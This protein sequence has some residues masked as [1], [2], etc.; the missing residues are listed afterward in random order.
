MTLTRSA[1]HPRG[2]KI[3][4]NA[5]RSLTHAGVFLDNVLRA[6]LRV[7]PQLGKLIMPATY[8]EIP[9][10]GKG[11]QG[12]RIRDS[13][14]FRQATPSERTCGKLMQRFKEGDI[15][16]QDKKRSGQPKKFDDEELQELL[17]ENP[18][19]TLKELSAQLGKTN[20]ARGAW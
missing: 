19:Q 1:H 6:W 9:Q 13:S 11:P 20:Y 15:E 16:V 12:R 5:E 4:G 7:C 14:H 2:T 3:I 10:R 8:F 18:A 17:D